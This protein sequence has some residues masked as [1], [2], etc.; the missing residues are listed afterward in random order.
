M[1]RLRH[2]TKE[3]MLRGFRGALRKGS[4]LFRKKLDD[5]GVETFK[6]AG[7]VGIFLRMKEKFGRLENLLST[8]TTP[9]YEAIRDNVLDLFVLEGVLMAMYEEKLVDD[10]Q[11]IKAYRAIMVS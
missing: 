11:L 5:Y 2:L 10:D 4:R 6:N 1:D 9:N 3:D 7:A 8:D